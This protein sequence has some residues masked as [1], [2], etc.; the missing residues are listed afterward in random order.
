MPIGGKHDRPNFCVFSTCK[1][2]TEMLSTVAANPNDPEEPIKDGTTHALDATMYAV[3]YPGAFSA[4]D[5][6][7]KNMVHNFNEIET[8]RA[9]KASRGKWGYGNG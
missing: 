6:K 1:K 9:K 8:A 2:T 3:M 4:T 5:D 7:S